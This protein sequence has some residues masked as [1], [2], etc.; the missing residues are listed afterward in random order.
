MEIIVDNNV[1]DSTKYIGRQIVNLLAKKYNF[2]SNDAINYLE[3]N[4]TRPENIQYNDSNKQKNTIPLPFC[5]YINPNCCQAVRLNYGLYTQCTNPCMVYNTEYP[6]CQTC[7]KQIEKN[8]NDQPTYGFISSRLAQGQNYRDPKGKAPT[9]YGNI[10]QKMNISKEDAELAAKKKG[11]VIPDYEFTV[12]TV[13]RGRPK[14]DTTAD[15][16]ESEASFVTTKTEKKRGRPKKNK[17]VVSV[18]DIGNN[19]LKDLINDVN[20]SN[21]ISS[22]SKKL[23][24]SNEDSDRE[25]D[26]AEAH[27]IKL[28]KKAELGYII[29]E[30]EADAD[31]LLTADNQLY[32]PFTHD[33]KGIWNATTKRVEIIDS[34][35][36]Y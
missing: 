22:E 20:N 16:T 36:E 4:T 7:N 2:D 30:S 13:S 19:M 34:D 12:K 1:I 11:L 26:G 23:P 14:K 32:T 21:T 9:N 6:V 18:D 25:S 31:Y 27:P 35:D 8:S 29:V 5:N 15:D 28:S 17:D 24:V 3:L 10:M 33:C